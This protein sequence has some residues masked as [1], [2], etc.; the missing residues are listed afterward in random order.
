MKK[1]IDETREMVVM[2]E[3]LVNK[4]TEQNGKLKS[5]IKQNKHK[6]KRSLKDTKQIMKKYSSGLNGQDQSIFDIQLTSLD[7]RS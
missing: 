6:R 2:Y 7:R 3:G 5:I 4:L 1:E